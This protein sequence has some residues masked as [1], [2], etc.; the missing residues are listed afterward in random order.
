MSKIRHVLLLVLLLLSSSLYAQTSASAKARVAE[1]R[2]MYAEIKDYRQSLKTAELPPN[3]MVITNDYMAAGAGPIHEVY[4]YYYSGDFDENLDVQVYKVHFITR[5]YNVGARQFY[6]ELLYNGDGTLAFY[7]EK[8]DDG[9]VRY[10]FDKGTKIH[11][12]VK[13]KDS[14]KEYGT[15][16]LLL[17]RYAAELSNAF[18]LLMNRSY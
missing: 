12:I 14:R 2:K 5:K 9:E 7:Y 15:D 1:I 11:E 6:E 18:S 3:E 17:H 13:G 4:S 8:G 16:L 10:Y